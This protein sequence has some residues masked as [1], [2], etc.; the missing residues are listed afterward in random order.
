MLSL[1][2]FSKELRGF[3]GI[4]III[5]FMFIHEVDN[6][7][8]RLYSYFRSFV[9]TVYVQY[10]VNY[11]IVCHQTVLTTVLFHSTQIGKHV[12]RLDEA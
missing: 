12:C 5:K 10:H 8:F 3:D 9:D 4:K 7:F 6:Y 11:Q 1:S 2:I